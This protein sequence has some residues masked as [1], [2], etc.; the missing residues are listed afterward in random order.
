MSVRWR[1]GTARQQIVSQRGTA[2]LMHRQDGMSPPRRLV[3][4]AGAT[5]AL[6]LLAAVPVQAAPS[7]EVIEGEVLHLVSVQDREAMTTMTPGETVTWD[8]RVSADEPDGSIELELD[9]A[10]DAGFLVGVAACADEGQGCGR[11]L[12]APTVVDGVTSLG[13][14][15]ADEV[16]WYRIGV[17]LVGDEPV[18]TVL[19]FTARG[20]GEEVS[21]DGEA[22][23]PG[24]G[25][26]PWL[27]VGLAL[28]ALLLGTALARLAGAIRQR[29]V[30]Q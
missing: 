26:S 29:A 20:Q 11:E 23:L 1:G 8:V 28:A 7:Q 2:V 5:L 22:E 17:R 10:G 9:A 14:Q 6:V 21:T 16:I 15:G 4:L 19:T 24:T 13:S 25:T 27:P 18:R 3:H 12:L 30:R